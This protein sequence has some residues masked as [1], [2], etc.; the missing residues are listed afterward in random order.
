MFTI[1]D[2]TE[3]D[4]ASIFPDLPAEDREGA[5]HYLTEYLRVVA[6]IYDRMQQEGKIPKMLLRA[7]EKR[8]KREDREKWKNN[9]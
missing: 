8:R 7:V 1:K 9:R 3:E 6:R 4:M 2:F 5:A